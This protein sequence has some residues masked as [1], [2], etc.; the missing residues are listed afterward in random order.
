MKPLSPPRYGS[1]MF[2]PKAAREKAR[3][4]RRPGHRTP[5]KTLLALTGSNVAL[6]FGAAVPMHVF[7]I[8]TAVTRMAATRHGGDRLA[9]ERETIASFLAAADW[10]RTPSADEQRALREWAPAAAAL[11]VRT[12]REHALLAACVRAKPRDVF[13]YQEALWAWLRATGRAP[14]HKA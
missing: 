10:T 6:N 14:K 13:A 8:T 4:D 12:R 7:E 9:M 3:I 1:K 2:M 11:G 5:E